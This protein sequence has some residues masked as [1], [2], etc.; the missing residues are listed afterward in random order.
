MINKQE[1]EEKNMGNEKKQIDF[2]ECFLFWLFSF[3]ID[4]S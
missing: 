4:P 2:S 1:E 3:K